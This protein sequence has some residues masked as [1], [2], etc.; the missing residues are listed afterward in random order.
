[1]LVFTSLSL[2]WWRHLPALSKTELFGD[3]VHIEVCTP[4]ESKL[5]FYSVSGF[6]YI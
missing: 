4:K 1:M 2:F 3:N 6:I 5:H